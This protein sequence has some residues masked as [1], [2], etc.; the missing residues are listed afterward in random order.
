ML[1][2]VHYEYTADGTRTADI[3]GDVEE[4]R[5]M[6]EKLGIMEH[7]GPSPADSR[8]STIFQLRSLYTAIAEQ[9]PLAALETRSRLSV[10]DRADRR[11][12]MAEHEKIIAADNRRHDEQFREYLRDGKAAFAYMEERAQSE[13]T[14]STGGF[15]VPQGFYSNLVVALKKVDGIF[16]ASSVLPTSESGTFQIPL[17]DDSANVAAIVSES[18]TSAAVD[19]VYDQLSF[20]KCPT[21]RSG[22]VRASLELAAD[23]FFDLAGLLAGS[24][25]RRFARGIGAA[26]TASLLTAATQGKLAASPTAITGD[27][28]LDLIASVDPAYSVNGAFLMN[29]TTLTAL[30]KLKGS[31]SGDYLLDFDIDAQGRLT[32][33]DQPVFI[34]PSMPAMTTGLK[35]VA[36]GDLSRFFRR[37]VLG[38]LTVKTLVERYAE[39]GQIAYEASWRVDGAL[40]K[41]ANSPVP[42]KYLQQA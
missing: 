14:G 41:A 1:V 37:E 22:Q 11:T 16:A 6:L 25:G 36:Y 32:L 34:S 29:L 35:S 40:A 27:E 31:T 4:F 39:V 2:R 30:R 7:A 15:I 26:H 33:F 38:S 24:F 20:G 21:W 18:G 19:S 5:G 12:I 13:L 3:T 9:F 28:L 17:D 8:A 10:R 23:S 42:V